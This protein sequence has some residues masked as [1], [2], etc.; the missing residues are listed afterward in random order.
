MQ[1]KLL[2]L[3]DLKK[4]I[5]LNFQDKLVTFQGPVVEKPEIRI[6]RKLD[7]ACA[8]RLSLTPA[9]GLQGKLSVLRD[10]DGLSGQ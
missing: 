2:N 1:G 5:F 3:G 10:N 9:A 7:D 8:D 6:W 4:G